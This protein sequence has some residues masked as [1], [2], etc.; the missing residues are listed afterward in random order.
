M[1]ELFATESREHW[2]SL[3]QR[4][5]IPSAVVATTSEWLASD[6]VANAGMRTTLEHPE[7]GPVVMPG[8]P[9]SFSAT[10]TDQLRFAATT[11]PDWADLATT[12]PVGDHPRGAP[13]ELAGPLAAI[14]VL[15]LGTFI[16]GPFGPMLLS[17]MGADVVK[18]E[19]TGGDPYRTVPSR[20][21][22]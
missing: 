6:V 13:E 12:R 3:L 9:I 8:V 11:A 17:G 2:V 19:A 14:E 15:D 21:S 5:G 4:A 18:I 20:A 16:A 1:T 10:P 7:Y 22:R